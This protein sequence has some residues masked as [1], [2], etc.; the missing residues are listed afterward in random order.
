MLQ[1]NIF[2]FS[3]LASNRQTTFCT[4]EFRT[5]NYVYAYCAIK[6]NDTGN[7][8]NRVIRLTE[9]ENRGTDQ[10]HDNIPAAKG[11]LYTGALA[12]GPDDKLY[13]ATG[14][15]YQT[16]Q[17]QNTPALTG[18]VLRINRNGTIPADNPFPK[19]PIYTLGHR[20]MFGI[21]FDKTTGMTIVTETDPS[22]YD[23][24][25]VLEK[26]KNYGFPAAATSTVRSSETDNRYIILVIRF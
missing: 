20:N 12:F 17:G 19:S 18:K 2:Y 22:H 10:R 3:F 16:E 25:N 24:I 11:S 14:Y 21:A 23:E 13:I 5:N 6:E 8:F 15:S 9:F 7:I 4:P 1:K 26:G